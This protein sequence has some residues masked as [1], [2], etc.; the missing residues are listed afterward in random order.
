[1]T[2]EIKRIIVGVILFLFSFTMFLVSIIIENGGFVL[3]LLWDAFILTMI[4]IGIA[5]ICGVI[6]YLLDIWIDK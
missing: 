4:A 3:G 1:M 2:K 6:I 5:V